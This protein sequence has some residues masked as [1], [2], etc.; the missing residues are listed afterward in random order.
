MVENMNSRHANARCLSCNRSVTVEQVGL[1]ERVSCDCCGW[2][3]LAT[4]YPGDEVGLI[5]DAPEEKVAVYILL[6]SQGADVNQIM[7]ARRQFEQ[8]KNRPIAELVEIA[9]T[10]RKVLIGIY[11]RSEAMEMLERSNKR[12]IQLV[13]NGVL[14]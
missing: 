9:K 13:L 4:V 11:P 7:E 3:E 1:L 10:D 12:D 8:L 5:G 2:S 14:G 6:P